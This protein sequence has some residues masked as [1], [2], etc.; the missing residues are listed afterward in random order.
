MS[1]TTLD[2]AG[3]LITVKE[4][5]DALGVSP[6][7]MYQL[8]HDQ[9]FRHG[10]RVLVQVD[11]LP[12]YQAAMAKFLETFHHRGP[13]PVVE[14]CR[15]VARPGGRGVWLPRWDQGRGGAPF[16][17]WHTNLDL[18]YASE[19]PPQL[20]RRAFGLSVAAMPPTG[21]PCGGIAAILELHP[22]LP[23]HPEGGRLRLTMGTRRR[24]PAPSQGDQRTRP[25]A[26]LVMS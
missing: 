10:H 6:W 13:G 2:T 22:A 21:R 14:V 18:T 25:L 9:A 24:R 20:V 7:V 1:K 17:D 26:N 23:D 4:A 19:R 3:E 15:N 5:A 11:S 8:V 12:E 16:N